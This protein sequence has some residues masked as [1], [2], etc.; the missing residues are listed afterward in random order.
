MEDLPRFER[1]LVLS[2][3]PIRSMVFPPQ[4]ICCECLI[5]LAVSPASVLVVA[6][7]SFST[8]PQTVP[9]AP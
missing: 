5:V 3:V 7:V 1:D 4:P 2:S 8:S 9:S 6:P